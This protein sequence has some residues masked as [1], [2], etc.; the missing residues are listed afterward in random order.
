MKIMGAGMED[1]ETRER[2]GMATG[3]SVDDDGEKASRL[4]S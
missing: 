1:V 4:G 2:Q 3:S